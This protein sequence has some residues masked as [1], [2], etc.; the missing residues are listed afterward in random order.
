MI[1]RISYGIGFPDICPDFLFQKVTEQNSFFPS[2]TSFSIGPGFCLPI[3]AC[4]GTSWGGEA[5]LCELRFNHWRCVGKSSFAILDQI[6]PL[7]VLDRNVGHVHLKYGWDQTR[8]WMHC[9]P[10]QL[11]MAVSWMLLT[12][13]TC[14]TTVMSRGFATQH[15]LWHKKQGT[16]GPNPCD[17]SHGSSRKQTLSLV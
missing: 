6:A 3:T 2:P 5:H 7:Q 16:E 13:L 15:V 12:C 11:D 1:Y 4:I 14:R 17:S 10:P 9:C 8:S